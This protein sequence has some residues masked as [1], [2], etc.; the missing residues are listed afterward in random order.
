MKSK[1]T[2]ILTLLIVLSG[3]SVS[4]STLPPFADHTLLP[5]ESVSRA[6]DSIKRFEQATG[7]INIVSV[8]DLNSE[9]PSQLE[10]RLGFFINRHGDL[11]LEL[12][13]NNGFVSLGSAV[14]SESRI[15]VVD[16]VKRIGLDSEQIK[17]TFVQLTGLSIA[18]N[19]LVMVLSGRLPAES[20]V[21]EFS[22]GASMDDGSVLLRDRRGE[23]EIAVQNGEIIGIKR[24]VSQGRTIVIR[25][26][27]PGQELGVING[28][29]DEVASDGTWVSETKFSL[30]N[31]SFTRP[32]AAKMF[33]LD[34]TGYQMRRRLN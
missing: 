31:R 19:D 11:R 27:H 22:S 1:C 23:L 25:R 4:R 7:L 20:A 6:V 3:C 9:N 14:I 21:V 2:L 15:T 24:I 29:V 34:T 17:N 16:R 10:A 5:P 33:D 28:T 13:P 8:L 26:P 32:I 18:P 12:Y 30:S